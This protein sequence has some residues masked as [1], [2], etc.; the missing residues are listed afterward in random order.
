MEEPLWL[1]YVYELNLV[2]ILKCLVIIKTIFLSHFLFYLNGEF[3]QKK[4]VKMEKN[5]F[6]KKNV[7]KKAKLIIS[8]IINAFDFWDF[9]S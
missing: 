8:I 6:P 3:S 5:T 4:I 2:E 1:A 9:L 7:P